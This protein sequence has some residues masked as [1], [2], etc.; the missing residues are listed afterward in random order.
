MAKN[1]TIQQVKQAISTSFSWRETV[2]KLGLNGDGGSNNKTF[3]KIASEYDID[4]SHFKGRGWNLG[5]QSNSVIPVKDLL[6]KGTRVRSDSLKKKLLKKGLLDNKC[7]E[8]GQMPIWNNKPLVLE[9]DHIDGDRENNELSNLRILCL[10]CHSQTSTWR[11]RGTK[12][13]KIKKYCKK[14]NKEIK[15]S[16]SGLC[17]SCSNKQRCLSTYYRKVKNRPSKEQLLKEIEE[18]NYCAVGRKHGVSDTCIRN[19]LK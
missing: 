5:K 1:Y 3:K 4:F 8:C 14:C 12:I 11:G 7:S 6:K 9:L 15:T 17:L 10:H 13:T 18:T 2:F 16:K 19:W